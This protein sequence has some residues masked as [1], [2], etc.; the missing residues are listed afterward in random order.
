MDEFCADDFHQCWCGLLDDFKNFPIGTRT[1]QRVYILLK[2][3]SSDPEWLKNK[4]TF[5]PDDNFNAF[6]EL[7]LPNGTK[8]FYNRK[9][10]LNL[11]KQGMDAKH[12]YD[13]QKTGDF[14]LRLYEFNKHYPSLCPPRSAWCWCGIVGSWKNYYSKPNKTNTV[15]IP[16]VVIDCRPVSFRPY[17]IRDCAPESTNNL[18]WHRKLF[19]PGAQHFPCGHF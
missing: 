19:G 2:I 15:D 17:E 4:N 10:Y 5:I 7:L 14:D 6:K 11:H 8:I 3:C 1:Q 13:Y 18:P 12:I 9:L 16:K